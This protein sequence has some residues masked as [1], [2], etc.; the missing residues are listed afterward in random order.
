MNQ[1]KTSVLPRHFKHDKFS[2]F[3]RQLN[4][5]GFRKVGEFARSLAALLLYMLELC[6]CTPPTAPLLQ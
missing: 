2:S 3:Q 1:F 5:Y 6:A 4:L